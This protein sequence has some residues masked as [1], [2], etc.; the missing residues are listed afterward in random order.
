MA[1]VD[2]HQHPPMNRWAINVRPV[3]G[4]EEVAELRGR[5][6]AC[7]PGA[8]RRTVRGAARGVGVVVLGGREGLGIRLGGLALV[9]P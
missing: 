3:P 4:L 1:A 5:R 6:D 8:A 7:G 2:R 9:M